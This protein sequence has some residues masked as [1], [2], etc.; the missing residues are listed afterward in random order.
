LA[1]EWLKE[2]R[3]FSWP[4]LQGIRAHS[5]RVWRQQVENNGEENKAA[6]DN[7]KKKMLPAI[8]GFLQFA[9]KIG[10][11]AP[12]YIQQGFRLLRFA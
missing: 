2:L 4:R 11:H 10:L 7:R 5:A 3:V 8:R 6:R 9:E 12:E 1:S